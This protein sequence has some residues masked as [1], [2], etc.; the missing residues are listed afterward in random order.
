MTG[1]LPITMVHRV[2]A[3]CGKEFV[4]ESWL[5][6]SQAEITTWG[7]CSR[8]LKLRQDDDQVREGASK[9]AAQGGRSEESPTRRRTRQP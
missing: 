2:C 4:R 6:V 3:W 8:C 5:G 9:G 7:I 1:E